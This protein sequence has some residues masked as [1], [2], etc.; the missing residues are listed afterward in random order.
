MVEF[1]FWIE[2]ANKPIG[3]NYSVIAFEATKA[4]GG[5]IPKPPYPRPLFYT[6]DDLREVLTELFGLADVLLTLVKPFLE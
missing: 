4:S 3:S 5:A 2:K 6:L 1:W